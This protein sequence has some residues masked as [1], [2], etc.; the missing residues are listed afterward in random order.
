MWQEK[1][2]RFQWKAFCWC[3]PLTIRFQSR[4]LPA[5]PATEPVLCGYEH[6]SPLVHQ[7]YLPLHWVNAL[8]NS[9]FA[10]VV[11]LL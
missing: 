10:Q 5:T 1:L 9:E 4:K 11:V 7:S 3:V 2:F 6:N 8:L